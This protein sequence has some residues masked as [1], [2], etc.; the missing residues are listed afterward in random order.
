MAPPNLRVQIRILPIFGPGKMELLDAIDRCGSI[1]AAARAMN[2]AYP[3]AWK[4]I[5]ALNRR[6]HQPLVARITGGR[7]GGGA[8][9][10]ANGRAILGLYRSVE[11]KAKIVFAGDLEAF[12]YLLAP[13]EDVT[14][15]STPEHDSAQE[16]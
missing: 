6:F 10:T 1:S 5:D 8:E 2:M 3:S 9:L 15:D 4:L 13:A 11:A 16:E 14:S 7:R 12:T